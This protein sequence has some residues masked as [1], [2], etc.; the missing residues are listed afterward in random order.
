MG[1]IQGRRP[2]LGVL[3][4]FLSLIICLGDTA[5]AYENTS[6]LP[7]HPTPVIDLARTL[8]NK[9]RI[10]LEKS[11]KEY[12]D[13]TG[14]KIRVL[15]QYEKIPGLAVKEFWGLDE[16]SL[17]LIADPRGGNLLNFN[18]G[19]ALFVLMPRIFWVELQTRYGNQY[20]VQEHGEDGAIIDA[21]ES[22]ETCLDRGG[23]NV[24]PGLSK[25]QW[26]WTLASSILG[27]II[28]GFVAFPRNENEL[29]AWGWLLLLAPL[30]LMLFGLFGITPV[31]TRTSETLPLLRNILAFLGSTIMAYLTAKVTLGRV[32]P[33]DNN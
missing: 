32:K 24:V 1:K 17:L 16:R 4:I 22:I 18:V 21:I 20:Y 11:L 27:G 25:D 29:I 23:C 8:T 28:A 13:K 2:F 33:T 7:D 10:S 30:W 6:L 3:A 15:S 5:F 12:E 19:D 31:I 9:E 26:L 14:W